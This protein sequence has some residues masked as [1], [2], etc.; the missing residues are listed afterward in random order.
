MMY[1]LHILDYL[2]PVHVQEISN[3]EGYSDG[4]VG[5]LIEVYDEQ[6]PDLLNA[7][8]VLLGCREE[9]G[10]HRSRNDQHGPDAI[11]REFYSLYS[12]HPDLR[13]A[14]IG[15]IKTGASLSDT[16]AA[17]RQVLTELGNLGKTVIFLG[18]SHDLSL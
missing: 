16:Y 5:S 7:D 1:S 6:F 2:D 17:I 13:L 12:W 15:N 9:R 11:R 10:A 3:D 18:G 14:D 8:L 4:Q